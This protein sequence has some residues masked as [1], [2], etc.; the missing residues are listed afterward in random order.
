MWNSDAFRVI[1]QNLDD[2]ADHNGLL[3]RLVKS[4]TD[5][6]PLD[7]GQR[8]CVKFKKNH[9][10]LTHDGSAKTVVVAVK[11]TGGMK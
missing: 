9:F 11:V 1:R 8:A 4:I 7:N 6:A 10:K 3:F 2:G 5:L